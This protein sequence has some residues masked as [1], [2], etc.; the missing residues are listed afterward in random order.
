MKPTTKKYRLS[1]PDDLEGEALLEWERVTDALHAQGRLDAADRALLTLYVWTWATWHAATRAVAREGAVQVHAN[2]MTGR[3]P[4][5]IVMKEMG[6]QVRALLVDL[7][8]TP[9]SGG[10]SRRPGADEEPLDI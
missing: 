7:K 2:K 10:A 6:I 8:L 5:F 3:N 4:A 9:G 1:P